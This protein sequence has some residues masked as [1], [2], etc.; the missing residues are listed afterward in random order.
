MG[1]LDLVILLVLVLGLVHGLF[2]G[3]VKQVV[4]LAAV[5]LGFILAA[6]F[7]QAA[8]EWVADAFGLPLFLGTAAGFALIF[9]AVQAIAFVVVRVM[10]RVLGA[11]HLSV[12]NRAAGGVAGVFRSAFL[13]SVI[14]FLLGYLGVPSEE[15]R[16]ESTLFTPVASVLPVA[17]NYVAEHWSTIERI[18]DFRR[19]DKG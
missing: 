3:L 6:V 1:T 15:T 18:P 5:I 12:L 8:G 11:L 4:G 7:R 19:R 13:I 9:T 14:L 17:W 16:R 10:E 2:T